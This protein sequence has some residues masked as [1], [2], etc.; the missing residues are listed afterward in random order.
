VTQRYGDMLPLIVAG[1][2]NARP[3]EDGI[4]HLSTYLQDAWTVAGTGPG[5]T[6]SADNP[7]AA[8]EIGRL[9]GMPGR[10][11]YVFAGSDFRVRSARLVGESPVDGV[12]LSDHAGVVADVKATR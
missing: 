8:A 12:W 10:I 3:D 11:D 9:D 4:R 1:D 7:L 5:L 2:L 6:W